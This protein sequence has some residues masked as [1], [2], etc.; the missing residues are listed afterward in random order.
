MNGNGRERSKAGTNQCGV[1]SDFS[2]FKIP[3]QC[4]LSENCV[5]LALFIFGSFNSL[6]PLLVRVDAFLGVL[7]LY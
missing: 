4:P 2:V 5:P 1:N 6:S 7:V 3:K